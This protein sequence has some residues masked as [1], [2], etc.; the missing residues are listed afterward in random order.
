MAISVQ[1]TTA[2][3]VRAYVDRYGLNYTV[4]FD[5]TS[6][7]FHTYRAFG[8]PT[9]LFLDGDGVIRKVVLGPI[10]RAEAESTVQGL[11]GISGSP[12]IGASSSGPTN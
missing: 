2:D 5:A 12:T 6:A 9:Q 3:D 8:L 7:V 1:E 4:G 10:T 11:L